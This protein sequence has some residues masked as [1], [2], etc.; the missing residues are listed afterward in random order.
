V[1]RWIAVGEAIAKGGSAENNIQYYS[2]KKSRNGANQW[3]GCFTYPVEGN[4]I[5]SN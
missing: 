2:M 1:T 3:Q 4:S 5:N